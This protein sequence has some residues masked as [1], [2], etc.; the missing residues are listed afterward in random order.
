VVVVVLLAGVFAPGTG[1]GDGWRERLAIAWSGMRGAISL[2]AALSVPATVEA[3]PQILFVTVVVILAT[4]VGQGLTLPGLLRA[5]RLQ[6]ERPWSPD[7]AIARLEA[8]Q[9][10]LDRAALLVLRGE[11]KLRPEVQRL[12]Q[13]DLDLEEARL[14]T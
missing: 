4:L 1:A 14:S 5:L 6:G 11:G 7:E 12:I 9:S 3:Q 10:A 13:R 2:V 8:A